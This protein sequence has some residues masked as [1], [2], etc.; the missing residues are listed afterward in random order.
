MQRP[1]VGMDLADDIGQVTFVDFC[2]ICGGCGRMSIIRT[3]M[4]DLHEYSAVAAGAE[5]VDI[6]RFEGNLSRWFTIDGR[7]K[8]PVAVLDQ[9]PKFPK[10]DIPD[11]LPNSV[12][13]AFKEAEEC[14]LN[15]QFSGAV[16]MYARACDL[17]I[18]DLLETEDRGDLAQLTLGRKIGRLE[19]SDLMPASMHDW[20]RMINNHRNRALHDANPASICREE[21]EPVRDVTR[22]VFMYL[23]TMP[24]MVRQAADKLKD[25]Q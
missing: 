6:A 4:G 1:K 12:A 14:Y 8:E 20:L 25:G 9:D 17:A 15:K 13:M 22:A 5:P 19:K 21:A 10:P 18:T 24:A 3:L 16:A 2:G 23:Y 7:P 11:N